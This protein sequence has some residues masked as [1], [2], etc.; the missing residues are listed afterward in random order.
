MKKDIALV[1]GNG[2]SKSFN[3]FHDVQKYSNTSNPLKWNIPNPAGEGLFL[4]VLHRLKKFIDIH[5]EDDD[6][7][8]FKK[9]AKI[10]P[11]G[12]ESNFITQDKHYIPLECRHYLSIA[13]SHYSLHVKKTIKSDWPWYK[14]IS[15]HKRRIGAVSSYNYDLIIEI[16]LERLGVYYNEA[17]TLKQYGKVI[18]HKPH[19]SCSYEINPNAIHGLK[20]EYPLKNYFYKTDT[21]FVKLN[22]RDML[23]PRLDPLCII[24]N[25]PNLYS[26]F[27]TMWQHE[28]KFRGFLSECSYC[29]FVG[30]SYMECDRPEVDAMLSSLKKECIVIIS[31]PSPCALMLEKI[32]SLGL[33]YKIWSNAAGPLD[34]HGDLILL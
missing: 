13:F 12:H 29:L 8:I 24:P 19:G 5:T 22:F 16:I 1:I 25:E 31:N 6:F 15:H 17:A 9:A 18:L 4:D 30:N 34:E 28:L 27:F 11:P 26:G 10:G 33:A 14:W 3:N 2:F 21:Q 32:K 7:T 20:K 23:E